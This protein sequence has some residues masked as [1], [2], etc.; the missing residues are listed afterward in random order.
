MRITL[1]RVEEEIYYASPSDVSTFG[2][3]VGEDDSR[4]DGSGCPGACEGEEVLFAEVGEAEEPEE[5]VG[6]GGE[7]AEVEAEG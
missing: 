1:W 2:S 7:D 3:D 4:S 6:E 5:G